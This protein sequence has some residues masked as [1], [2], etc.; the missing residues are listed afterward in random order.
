VAVT[1]F[2]ARL[3]TWATWGFFALSWFAPTSLVWQCAVSG[4][5]GTAMMTV[6]FVQ[7]TR[8]PTPRVDPPPRGV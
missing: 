1:E 7:L 8:R 5:I 6:G 2:L 4:A 3:A